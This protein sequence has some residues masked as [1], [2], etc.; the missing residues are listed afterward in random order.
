MSEG[1]SEHGSEMDGLLDRLGEELQ[2]LVQEFS[3]YFGSVEEQ[4]EVDV[5]LADFNF[6]EVRESL[7]AT[8]VALGRPP[9]DLVMSYFRLADVCGPELLERAAFDWSDR[10]SGAEYKPSPDVPRLTEAGLPKVEE[11][12]FEDLGNGK[13][14]KVYP[15]PQEDS[16]RERVGDC[17]DH[18]RFLG[19]YFEDV[20]CAVLDALWAFDR[21]GAEEEMRRLEALGREVDDALCLW[22][23]EVSKLYE[24]SPGSLGHA[25]DI[26]TAFEASLRKPR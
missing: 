15:C 3:D 8:I 14:L 24:E 6:T 12:E 11:E 26:M 7:G 4:L 22:E 10:L 16:L 21:V 13:S 25:G 17:A 2:S 19:R 23:R 9:R 20:Q 1:H 5:D 18:I